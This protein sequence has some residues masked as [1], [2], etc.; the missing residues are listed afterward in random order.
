VLDCISL[1]I[2]VRVTVF[3]LMLALLNRLS[4]RNL[5]GVVTPVVAETQTVMAWLIHSKSLVSEKVS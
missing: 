5:R 1:Y 4:W 2:F 3:C